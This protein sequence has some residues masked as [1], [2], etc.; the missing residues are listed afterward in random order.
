MATSW[1][2]KDHGSTPGRGGFALMGV[3]VAVA[4]IAIM[5]AVLGPLIYRQLMEARIEAT[6]SEMLALEDALLRFFADTGRFPAEAEGLAALLT[7]PG[8]AGWQGPYL[9]GERWA[10]LEEITRDDFGEPYI[11]DRDPD[12]DPPGETGILLVSGGSDNTVTCGTLNGTWSINDTGND[13]LVF[14]DAGP[15]NRDKR[16][17]ARQLMQEIAR[18][19][20]Q[21]FTDNAA[22]PSTMDELA[23]T[24]R[25]ESFAGSAFR[26]PWHTA[27]VLDVDNGAHP[28]TMTITSLGP[29]RSDN[30]GTGD[31]I[32]LAVDSVVPGRKST[33]Y[34]LGIIQSRVDAQAAVALTGDWTAD[35][36]SLNL[37][38]AFT[39]DGWGNQFE[40][41]MS[42]RTILSAGPD[43]DYSTAADN[44]PPGIVPDDDGATGDIEFVEGSAVVTGP[45]HHCDRIRLEIRNKSANDVVL[46]SVTATWSSPTAFYQKVLIDGNQLANSSNPRFA[47]GETVTFS[48]SFTLAGGGT[49]TIELRKFTGNDHGSGGQVDMGRADITLD[50][51]DGSTL[52]LTLPA[53]S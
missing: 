21:F 42:T 33:W 3:L 53:C 30:S 16:A 10:P 20:Q 14:I 25:D 5:A 47:S 38:G 26:D 49:T 28:P 29:D 8:V 13:I 39:V 50:F 32:V 48:N 6:R 4:V 45:H 7:D 51:S 24:Y 12:T 27:F 23:G 43:A 52:N 22:F 17:A 18:A 2:R 11:Y 15:A 1:T 40:E 35:R 37:A 9:S 34:A 41:A 44:I 36:A 19:A 31:D 46:T